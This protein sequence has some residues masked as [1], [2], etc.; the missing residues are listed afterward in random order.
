MKL[1]LYGKQLDSNSFTV[2]DDFINLLEK[3]GVKWAA[4]KPFWETTP[5][6]T[7]SQH[8]DPFLFS[9]YRELEGFSPDILL[10]FGGDGTLLDS[11]TLVASNGIPVLG[12]NAGRMGF[13]SSTSMK[14]LDKV[15][16]ELLNGQYIIEERTL[17]EFESAEDIFDDV[18]LALNDFTI[19][20]R[21]TSSMLTIHTYLDGELLNT[22]W[23]DG[24]IIATPTGSTAYSLSCGGPVIFP[25]TKSFVITPVAS[26]NITIRPI[27]VPDETQISFEVEGR[28]NNFLISL[29]SR[30]AVVDYDLNFSVKKSASKLKFVKLA[31]QHFIN[32]LR[33]KLMMGVDSRNYHFS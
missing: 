26:H 32:T 13:L 8:R 4:Y 20:K 33:E 6:Q 5:F 22:Y 10:S 15:L 3:K 2:L 11:L 28:G 29:D 31:D 16:G 23:S 9:D 27:I 24:L 21:D 14:N 18:P 12:I 7:S 30:Y 25:N 17:L 1:A 19:N